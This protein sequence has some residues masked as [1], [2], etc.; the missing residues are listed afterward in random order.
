MM[1][2]I[3]YMF[4]C[5]LYFFFSE[6]T[7]QI[8]CPFLSWVISFHIVEFLSV[9]GIFWVI[10]HYQLCL[11]QIVS[12]CLTAPIIGLSSKLLF[13]NNMFHRDLVSNSRNNLSKKQNSQKRPD[14]RLRLNRKWKA[15]CHISLT[16]LP[17]FP[18]IP[19]FSH[20]IQNSLADSPSMP[21]HRCPDHSLSF[22]PGK[23]ITLLLLDQHL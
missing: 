18:C 15:I 12:F 3:F 8:V 5:Y 23:E 11:L 13:S 6:V 10:I 4:I 7:V 14:H 21:P 17:F 20:S 1:P 2:S 9:I 22:Q 19:H 16:F